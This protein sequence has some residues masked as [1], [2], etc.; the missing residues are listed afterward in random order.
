MKV[1]IF[2]KGKDVESQI[3]KCLNFAMIH[4]IDEAET[5]S[6]MPQA[7]ERLSKRDINAVLIANMNVVAD[8]EFEYEIIE[9]T[10]ARYR[11]KLIIVKGELA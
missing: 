8:D 2:G 7:I 11:A 1:L 3:T 10:F 4:G 6:N 9:S 5:V